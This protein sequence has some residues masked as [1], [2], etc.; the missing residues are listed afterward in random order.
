LNYFL[1]KAQELLLESNESQK[2]KIHYLG[3]GWLLLQS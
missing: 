2:Y 3:Y 1:I